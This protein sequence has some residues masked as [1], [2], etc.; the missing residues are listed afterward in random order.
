MKNAS[1][2]VPG[3]ASKAPSPPISGEASA[4]ARTYY[5]GPADINCDERV[6]QRYFTYHTDQGLVAG[7]DCSVMFTIDRQARDVWPYL[8]DFNLWQNEHRH[9]YSGV[10]GD[11]EGRT[12]RL[13]DKPNDA[14]P[15]YYEVLKVIPEYL[16]AI[17]QPV[18]A[19]SS[20][21]GFPGKGGVSPG[22][23]VFTLNEHG[24]K[25]TVT[26][27]MEHAAI[28]EG[29]GEEAVTPW[30]KLVEGGWQRKWREDF[31]RTLKRLVYEGQ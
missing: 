28:A 15:H 5:E 21:A 17:N 3:A 16:I 8:K 18:P 1:A 4:S 24:G 26:A 30:R 9:Y 14:G 27:F 19:D 31:I 13:S 22:F 20:S 2:R 29:T 11:L 23:H 6:H 25:T 10:L 12:F 7:V